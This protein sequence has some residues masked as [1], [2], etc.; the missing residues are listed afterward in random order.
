LWKSTWYHDG[1]NFK[2]A[3]E[4]ERAAVTSGGTVGRMWVGLAST[5]HF[6]LGRVSQ[7]V[8]ALPQDLPDRACHAKHFQRKSCH[9]DIDLLKA[10]SIS[11]SSNEK[12]SI[13]VRIKRPRHSW[14]RRKRFPRAWR[15][16]VGERL[17]GWDGLIC[18]ARFPRAPQN[19][20]TLRPGI[21]PKCRTLA[22]TTKQ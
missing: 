1:L 21:A 13:L 18:G 12:L 11:H 6:T 19:G 14:K 16:P 4:H 10:A 2:G 7:S 20:T 15:S 5:I 9:P 8:F 22:V 17:A 3:T